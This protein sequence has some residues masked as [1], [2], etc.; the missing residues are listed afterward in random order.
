MTV[1]VIFPRLPPKGSSASRSRVDSAE[2]TIGTRMTSSGL[3][4]ASVAISAVMVSERDEYGGGEWLQDHRISI[5]YFNGKLR[6]VY[7]SSPLSA[8]VSSRSFCTF[9]ALLVFLVNMTTEL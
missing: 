7:F 6:S 4:T 1:C 9:K 8:E 5:S 3:P 2:C